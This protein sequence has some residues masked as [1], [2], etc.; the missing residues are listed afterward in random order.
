[1]LSIC[2]VGKIHLAGVLGHMALF[3]DT[4]GGEAY[5]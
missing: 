4:K 1:M 2:W 5:N 3:V